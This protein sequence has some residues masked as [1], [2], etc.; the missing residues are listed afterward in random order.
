M[1]PAALPADKV[2]S[3]KKKPDVYVFNASGDDDLS[4]DFIEVKKEP[5]EKVIFHTLKICILGF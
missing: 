1:K 4:I 3:M 5:K 2:T